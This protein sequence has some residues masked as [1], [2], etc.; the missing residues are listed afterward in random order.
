M[1]VKCPSITRCAALITARREQGQSHPTGAWSGLGG[2]L[3]SLV[4]K[5]RKEKLDGA[6]AERAL[7]QFPCGSNPVSTD[8]SRGCREATRALAGQ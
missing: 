4:Q 7:P 3:L 8:V 6:I 2:R 1:A 5:P